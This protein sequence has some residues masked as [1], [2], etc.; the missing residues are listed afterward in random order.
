MTDNVDMSVEDRY[1]RQIFPQRLKALMVQRGITTASEL[2][3]AT[4]ISRRGIDFILD[5]TRLPSA[6]TLAK[7]ADGLDTT[8]DYLLFLDGGDW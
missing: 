1:L 2:S 8:V 6:V 4:G 3:R 5:G 7:L